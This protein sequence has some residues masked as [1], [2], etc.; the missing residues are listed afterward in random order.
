MKSIW[1]LEEG[2]I[3]EEL[4]NDKFFQKLSI[5][6]Q[7]LIINNLK[8]KHFCAASVG[9][10]DDY[11]YHGDIKVC[12]KCQ[13]VRVTSCSACGCGSCETCGYRYSCMPV[14]NM[15]NMNLNNT[16]GITYFVNENGY[17]KLREM[18]EDYSI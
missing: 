2:Q 11:I 1:N 10:G 12:P 17:I 14:I 3:R 7:E 15:P 5:N 9:K 18:E 4:K 16:D 6:N 13:E 8:K